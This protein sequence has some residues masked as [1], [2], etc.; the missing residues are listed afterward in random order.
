MLFREW[1]QIIQ[2]SSCIGS[3]SGR[4]EKTARNGCIRSPVVMRQSPNNRLMR[5]LQSGKR[6]HNASDA[7]PQRS[8]IIQQLG[9]EG[10][11][12]SLTQPR[13]FG[14]LVTA[15]LELSCHAAGSRS[16]VKYSASRRFAPMLMR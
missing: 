6:T 5:P 1:E 9:R 2:F 11:Q 13:S 14:T 4:P 16:P 10:K 8:K 3:V 7:F 12:F 15:L